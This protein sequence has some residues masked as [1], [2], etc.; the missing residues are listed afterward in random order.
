[1]IINVAAVP[2]GN[3]ETVFTISNDD[4]LPEWPD[5]AGSMSCQCRIDRHGRELGVAIS[6]SGKVNLQCSRCLEGFSLPVRGSAVA[7]IEPGDPQRFIEYDE[8][9]S[10]FFYTDQHPEVDL[11][12][13]VYDELMVSIPLMPLCSDTCPGIRIKGSSKEQAA[14]SRSR[15]DEVDPRWEA[16]KKLRRNGA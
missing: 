13:V 5:L 4:K 1:M 14:G 8:D 10:V 16:L 15:H 6:F 3:S 12:P 11:S 9:H 7:V 2:E